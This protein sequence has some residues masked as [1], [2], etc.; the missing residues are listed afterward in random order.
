MGTPSYSADFNKGL[1]AAHN[2]DFATAFKEWK[3]LAQ[4]GDADAQYNLG[5]MY[6]KG[7]GVIQDYKEAVRLYRRAAEQGHASAQSNLANRYYYGEGVIKDIVYAHM[8]KNISASNGR[9]KSR[10]E[11]KT[12]EKK[13]TT[14]DISEAQRLARECVRKNYKGC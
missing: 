9:D 10:E 5:V 1:T 6:D 12:I 11:L 14:L 4:Q 8:W 2:G 7:H 13:M 3:P